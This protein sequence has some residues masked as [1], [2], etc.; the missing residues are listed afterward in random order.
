MVRN[1][2]KY[3]TEQA[4]ERRRICIRGGHLGYS[5][6]SQE[7][8]TFYFLSQDNRDEYLKLCLTLAAGEAEVTRISVK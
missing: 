3:K 6:F 1:C 5:I 2:P 7:D 4:P 8:A